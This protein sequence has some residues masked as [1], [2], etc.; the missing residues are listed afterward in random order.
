[1]AHAVVRNRLL[2]TS[3]PS[4]DNRREQ[5]ALAQQWRPP[6]EQREGTA[7]E[8]DED[9]ED[10]AAAQRIG[11][12]CVDRGEHA[13]AHQEGADQRQREGEDREQ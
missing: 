10:E 1:V 13:R 12:E 5:S 9:H 7:D 2:K 6:C 3:A 11:C 8:Q 4:R